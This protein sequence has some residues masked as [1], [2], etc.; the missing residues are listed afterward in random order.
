MDGWFLSAKIAVRAAFPAFIV[1]FVLSAGSYAQT[2]TAPAAKD[3]VKACPDYATEVQRDRWDMNERTDLGFRT[4]NGVYPFS[5]EQPPSYLLNPTFSGGFFTA[6]SAATGS[7][8]ASDANLSILDSAYPGSDSHGNKFGDLFPIDADK[9]QVFVARMYVE[10]GVEGTS[11]AQFFWSIDS[12][13]LTGWTPNG[14]AT[15]SNPF[16]TFDGWIYY[17]IDLPALGVWSLPGLRS[18]PWQGRIDS[19]RLD[20]LTRRDKEFRIDWIRLVEKGSA[21]QRTIAWSGF[22]GNVDL[23]LDGDRNAGNGM[24]GR[25][26][27][28]VGGTSYAFL[29]GALAAGNYYVAVARTGT[30]NFVYSAGYYEVT[31]QPIVEIVKP[32]AEGSDEDYVTTIWGDPWDMANAQDVERVENVVNGGFALFTMEDLNGTVFPNQTVYSGAAAP[33]APGNVGDPI[34]RLIH[35]WPPTLRGALGPIDTSRYHN[36]VLR[37]G[38]AGPSSYA[39]GSVIRVVWKLATESVE[40]VARA[41]VIRHAGDRWIRQT[42]VRDLNTIQLEDGGGSPSHSG[43]T[44]RVDAFRVDP[45]EFSDQRTFFIDEVRLAAD[46]RADASFTI[47]WNLQDADGAPAVS[48]YYDNDPVGFN[49]TLIAANLAGG[50]YVWNT[51]GMPAGTYYLYAVTS[52]GLNTNR[53]YAGGPLIVSHSGGGTP[54]IAVS[55]TQMN[56]GAVQGGPATASQDVVVSNEGTGTLNW[57]AARSVPWIVV[58]PAA[59]TGAGTLNVGVNPAGLGGGSHAGTVTVSDPNA[60]NSPRVI[61]VRLSV[62]GGGETQPPFGVFET[63]ADGQ[64]GI[65]GSIA[66]TGWALDDIGLENV[67]IY[68]DPAAGE[69]PGP[70]GWVFIGDAVFV[71]GA[72]P[73]VEQAFSTFPLCHCAGWGY[74]MLTN[75]LPNQGNGTFRVHAVATDREGSE[76]SLG[77]RSITCANAAAVLPFGAIDTPAQ[78]GAAS[79]AAFVNF[80]WVLTPQP[81]AIAADGSTIWV[82]VDGV[83]LGHPAYG[84]YRPDIAGLFPGYLNSN[85]ASG[86]SFVDTTAYADGVHTI[87]W[88]ATD[89]AGVDNGFGS[90]YFTIRN[91]G[92]AVQA[93]GRDHRSPDDEVDFS[94]ESGAPVYV[95]GG[96]DPNALPRP[97]FPEPDGVVRLGMPEVGRITVALYGGASLEDSPNF[98][99]AAGKIPTAGRASLASRRFEASHRVVNEL[100]PLPIG[101]SFDPDR[102]VFAWHPGPGFF[103]EYEFVFVR[104]ESGRLPVRTTV[105]IRVGRIPSRK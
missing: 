104:R 41:F 83:P 51:S 12:G 74:M 17:F 87:V 28:N 57:T 91:A 61:T 44:G 33:P 82:W 48:L 40:N 92:A 89:S 58:A 68:R 54:V 69:T 47:L 72:R 93:L 75:F 85:G 23:Y 24:L 98:F 13:Y 2:V 90:R 70:N 21:Y 86:H 9:Y 6:R 10:P 43:W 55:R 56:F 100:R 95:A 84:Y 34:V 30:T 65:E 22:G 37:A 27:R 45:H 20:P 3:T 96:F 35:F 97:V 73:D 5:V 19:L 15:A 49:G 102:G 16:S 31:E 66:V 105:R 25:L 64:A 8:S 59:G 60:P 42:F 71:E 4:Y 99:K 77:I 67:K 36:L 53:A 103:G 7:G 88:S 62:Y 14:G 11:Q 80:G 18:D 63:P 1:G 38:I 46:W 101:A 29:A 50:S 52:D 26:A 79:G 81:K 78:G 39:D 94:V 32:S 76:T